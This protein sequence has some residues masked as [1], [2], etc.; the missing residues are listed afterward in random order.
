MNV[1]RR[2]NCTTR[3]AIGPLLC[4]LPILG[5]LSP[6]A[7]VQACL[8]VDG[9]LEIDGTLTTDCVDV[10]TNGCIIIKAGGTLTLTG[11]PGSTSTVNGCIILE[12]SGSVLSFTTN[13]HTVVG[14]GVIY[15][16]YNSA[17]ISI[18]SGITL[19][20]S[21]TIQ[22]ALEIKDATTSGSFVNQGKVYANRA[23]GNLT[24]SVDS[25]TDSDNGG[26]VSDTNF[27][28]GVNASGAKLLFK[29]D[30]T[31]LLGDF[32]VRQSSLEVGVDPEGGDDIDV[33]S[34]GDTFFDGGS[35]TALV[36]DSFK[37][38]GTCP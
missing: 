6:A 8:D 11:D 28:W 10:D 25:V 14:S 1:A 22:G 37:C 30:A 12:G 4:M 35:I 9:T 5:L 26:T 21:T 27:R 2:I 3:Q 32:F 7:T 33:C 31:G 20:S 38:S 19:T 29:V 16:Q 24:I 18:A 17:V 13:S 15:G 23:S 36:D 34:T